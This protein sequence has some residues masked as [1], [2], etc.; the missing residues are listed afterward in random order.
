MDSAAAFNWHWM[1][2]GPDR[3]GGARRKRE[4]KIILLPIKKK[5]IIIPNQPR[6][7]TKSSLT[8]WIGSL[9]QNNYCIIS[10]SDNPRI[11]PVLICMQNWVG[12]CPQD[13]PSK[14]QRRKMSLSVWAVQHKKN[15]RVRKNV[16]LCGTAVQSPCYA[17]YKDCCWDSG[18]EGK[19]RIKKL[20][21]DFFFF[22]PFS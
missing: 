10:S 19:W 14:W 6:E 15:D 11:D 18:L 7:H 1:E 4:I 13:V 3:G 20:R 9:D 12:G 16:S 22:Y 5:L 17:G 21:N 8:Q 2:G